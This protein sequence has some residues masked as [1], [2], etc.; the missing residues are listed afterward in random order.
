MEPE[1]QTVHNLNPT[2]VRFF[3]VPTELIQAE[4]L[5]TFSTV[6]HVYIQYW[7]Y[8]QKWGILKDNMHSS[9]SLLTLLPSGKR[10]RSICCHI[11]RLRSSFSSAGCETPQ[12]T[13]TSNIWLVIV[14]HRWMMLPVVVAKRSNPL[15]A[16]KR[17]L[18]WK[19]LPPKINVT[20]ASK[21]T[22]WHCCLIVSWSVVQQHCISHTYK[23]EHFG[24]TRE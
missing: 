19:K 22:T 12:P 16:L 5:C 8:I 15:W 24:N 9:H 21:C 14:V 11:T 13:A 10:Y 20:P 18:N 3:N 6:M 17:G 23:T 4:A 7:S 1:R 2:D